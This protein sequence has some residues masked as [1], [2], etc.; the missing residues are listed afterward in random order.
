[1]LFLLFGF[2]ICLLK[3]EMGMKLSLTVSTLPAPTPLEF[4]QLSRA[5]KLVEML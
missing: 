1:M 2:F 3:G 4:Q 5:E